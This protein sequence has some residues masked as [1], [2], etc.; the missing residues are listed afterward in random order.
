MRTAPGGGSISSQVA[1]LREDVDTID[2][3]LGTTS[4][5]GIGDGTVTGGLSAL[6]GKLLNMSYKSV[7]TVTGDGNKTYAQLTQE[8]FSGISSATLKYSIIEDSRGRIFHNNEWYEFTCVAAS[9]TGFNSFVIRTISY[10]K[11]GEGVGTLTVTNYSDSVAS[12]GT[13][14]TLM[15]FKA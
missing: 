11:Y 9:D 1:E 14:F 13:S 6:N 4:I 10:G 7:K 3:L 8:L 2:A 15:T 5:S 12:S